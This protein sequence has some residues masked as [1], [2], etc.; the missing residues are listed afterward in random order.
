LRRCGCRP[1]RRQTRATSTCLMPS[2]FASFRVLQ[3]V[4]PSGG[5][6]RVFERIRASIAWVRTVGGQNHLRSPGIFRSKLAAP[7]AG[8]QFSAFIGSQDQRHT[9][10][11][12]T[13]KGQGCSSRNYGCNR[14]HVLSDVTSRSRGQTVRGLV[15]QCAPPGRCPRS[16]ADRR[17]EPGHQ[18]GGDGRMKR[19]AKRKPVR[20]ED[21]DRDNT[22]IR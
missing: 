6:C 8:F 22:S 14:R 10:Q 9:A 12:S 17:A 7:D 19:I 1:A 21:V 16:G 13:T 2:T 3:W 11:Q 20:A 5:R 4:L 15:R 18:R